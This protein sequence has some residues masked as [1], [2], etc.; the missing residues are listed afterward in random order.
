[1]NVT[2]FEEN[3]VH[4]VASVGLQKH[5]NITTVNSIRSIVSLVKKQT[6]KNKLLEQ[7]DDDSTNKNGLFC[8]YL[9]IVTA[10]SRLA[11]Y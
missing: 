7:N 3:V 10:S 6:K 5:C 9:V 11:A 8:V 4:V 1:M 2:L